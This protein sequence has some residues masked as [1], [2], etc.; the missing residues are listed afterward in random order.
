MK[1]KNYLVLLTVALCTVACSK[2][3]GVNL[4][5][6]VAGTYNGYTTSS[7]FSGSYTSSV[8]GETVAITS[9]TDGT[10]RIVY[11]S[12]EWGSFIVSDATVTQTNGKYLV[13]GSGSIEMASHGAGT[14]T[15]YPFT[16]E[17]SVSQDKSSVVILFSI[18]GVMNGTDITFYAGDMPA[19][20]FVAGNY[21]GTVDVTAFGSTSM[22]K[23]TEQTVSVTSNE[24]GTVKVVYAGS[25]WGTAIIPEAT[26]RV[27][28]DGTYSIEG[29]GTVVTTPMSGGGEVT[30]SVTLVGTMNAD[31]TKVSLTFNYGYM[32]LVLVF[33][34]VSSEE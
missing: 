27:A 20:L 4:S 23:L 18:P 2:D 15:A 10:L 24:E 8:A 16:V 29:E 19:H 11:T 5:E 9:N 1:L 17:G 26:V 28:T 34:N 3:D 6:Q 33:N 32:S 14:A 31:K 7:F 25:T 22:G 30:Y 13:S 21:E 12:E